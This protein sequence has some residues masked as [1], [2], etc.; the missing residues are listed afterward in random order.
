MSE[1]LDK[2]DLIASNE[3]EIFSIQLGKCFIHVWIKTFILSTCP[4]HAMNKTEKS[5]HA[6]VKLELISKGLASKI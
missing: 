3:M 6:A 1:T 5:H 4:V 2:N